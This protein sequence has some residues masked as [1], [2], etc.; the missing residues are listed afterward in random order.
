MKFCLIFNTKLLLHLIKKNEKFIK[1]SNLIFLTP[2]PLN[3]LILKKNK[4]KVINLE[5]EIRESKRK[6][7]FIK[8]YNFLDKKIRD[9]KKNKDSNFFYNTFR[10]H[11][12]RDYVGFKLIIYTV[13]KIM[14]RYKAKNLI[15]LNDLNGLAFKNYL[16]SELFKLFCRD[17][18]INF[19]SKKFNFE[20]KFNLFSLV[21]KKYSNIKELFYFFNLKSIFNLCNKLLFLKIE[22]DRILIIGPRYDLKYVSFKK[23]T[24]YQ[25]NFNILWNKEY[26]QSKDFKKFNIS[27]NK[28][29][30]KIVLEYLDYEVTIY[31]NDYLQKIS[32]FSKFLKEKK[33][34]KIFWAL[35]PPPVLRNILL[36]IL[37]SKKLKIKI[38]GVQHGG[39]YFLMNHEI[40]NK[41][42]DFDYCNYYLAYGISNYF[43][44]KKFI[45]NKNLKLVNCGS[46][47]S[48]YIK[49]LELDNKINQSKILYIPAA[50]MKM[51]I[52]RLGTSAT[53]FFNLQM[54]I[55]N[56]L[57]L[58]KNFKSYIKIIPN[59]ISGKKIHDYFSLQYNSIYYELSQFTNIK[60]NSMPLT[61]A[62]KTI[63]PKIIIC[64]YLS[65]PI[66]EI[67]KTN[68]EI[69]LFM[70]EIN[71][72][73]KDVFRLLNKRIFLVK[74]MKQM[75]KTVKAIEK[76]EYSKLDN[77]D[78]YKNFFDLKL[79]NNSII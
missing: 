23:K 50:R 3:Y 29:Y 34:K 54:K 67:I 25:R 22:K 79:K 41:D 36:F 40:V 11:A 69:I 62:I 6:Q 42:S 66:Y 46:F 53:S 56:F 61:Q 76:S 70:D 52:P 13:G 44:K 24:V 73:K 74:N 5:N 71:V 45:K 43:N 64:D 78:F 12:P 33:I 21:L 27:K 18:Y 77:D 9:Y 1:S 37:R 10:W 16:Y 60:I 17:N 20:K 55:C 49:H 31:K 19:I 58:N 26:M 35:S 4:V 75:L 38:F 39:Q 59:I 65:T 63:R 68:C 51:E 32:L 7:F 47:K 57:N 2:S 14:Q 28:K 72:I 48:N 15:Y 30:H 8:N